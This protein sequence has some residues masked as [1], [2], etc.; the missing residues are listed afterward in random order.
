LHSAEQP[1]VETDEQEILKACRANRGSRGPLPL[2]HV[3]YSK[4]LHTFG[5]MPQHHIAPIHIAI[6]IRKAL[7]DTSETTS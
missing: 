2:T 1:T 3:V 6:V 5:D 7:I 4:P